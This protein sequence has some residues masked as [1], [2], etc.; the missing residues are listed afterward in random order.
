MEK[1]RNGMAN[2]Y[3]LSAGYNKAKG[4]PVKVGN[5]THKLFPSTTDL[6]PVVV[7]RTLYSH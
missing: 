5:L 7:S 4:C 3:G 1:V 6:S 2:G